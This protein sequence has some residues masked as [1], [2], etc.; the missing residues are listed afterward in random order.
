[1]VEVAVIGAGAAGLVA[2]RHLLGNGLRPFIFEAAKTVGGSWSDRRQGKMWKGLSTNLSKHTCRFSEWP[3]PEDT[4]T[5]PTSNEMAAYLESYANEFVDP[6]CFN[7]QCQVNH[8]ALAGS[9]E[10]SPSSSQVEK[11]Y[12]V[13]WTDLTTNSTHS[14]EFNGVVVAT[15]F[16][17]RPHWPQQLEHNTMEKI[18]TTTIIHSNDYYNHQDFENETVA[19]IGSSFSALEIAV[20]VSKSAQRVVSILPSIPWVFP[21]YIPSSIK[22]NTTTTATTTS[23]ILPIDL[24]FYKRT[25]NYPQLEQ[26]T[27]TPTSAREKHEH[28]KSLSGDR[29]ERSPMGIPVDF[30]VP[31]SIAISDYYLDLVVDGSIDVIHG[32][33]E[34]VD[35]KGLKVVDDGSGNTVTR[36][37][38]DIT[39]VICCTGYECNIQ[40]FLDEKILQ[41]LEYD[42]KDTFCPM[43]LSYDTL[44]P[45]LPNMA[46]CGMYRGPYMGVMELQGRLAAASLS[47]SGDDDSDE[48]SKTLDQSLEISKRIRNTRPRAQFPHFDYLGE[49]D[50]I[51][52]QA[53]TSSSF[54]KYNTEIGD[55]V[56][57]AFYQSDDDAVAVACQNELNEEIEKGRHG[58]RMPQIVASAIIG[59][60][61]FDRRIVHLSS[62]SSSP[63]GGKEEHVYG[64]IRY[65]RS[66]ELDYILY[67]ED[68]LYELTPVKTLN[69]FREYE[70]VVQEDGILEIYFVESGKRAHLFLSLK[71]TEQNEQGYWV[72]SNDHLCIKDLYKANFQIKLDGLSAKEII[73]TYRV[74]GPAKDYESTTVMTPKLQKNV[75]DR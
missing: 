75:I 20:D 58:D 54:P 1:M 60:W 47:S 51:T 11:C 64:T 63:T 62:L 39:K 46:F 28:L 25:Q 68:G 19:V 14:K 41:T 21:R 61:N 48:R 66:K 55:M 30:E 26:I 15:G 27:F 5:F 35:E 36:V 17:S 52:H 18:P 45:L 9:D 6:S 31:P 2:S 3:W 16:F 8:I 50:T 53:L 4:G 40:E 71:F 56:S 69:V 10:S 44:H 13:E 72:A 32:R 70:Y 7:F 29:Q 23:S 65:S 12:R 67:R 74:K 33:F 57:P 24:A 37:I 22:G 49:M 43:T 38:P 73:I 42:P 59:T 34:D